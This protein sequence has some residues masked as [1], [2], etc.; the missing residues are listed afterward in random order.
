MIFHRIVVK[1]ICMLKIISFG[2]LKVI[3]TGGK[4]DVD[5]T[6]KF[7]VNQKMTLRNHK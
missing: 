2:L 6:F 5:F 4:T 3:A 7:K 1:A